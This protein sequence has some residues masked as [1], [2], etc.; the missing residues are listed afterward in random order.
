MTD[1]ED[2]DH[3][4]LA[5]EMTDEIVVEFS[6]LLGR[7][8]TEEVPDSGLQNA[9]EEAERLI[10]EIDTLLE[11]DVEESEITQF[12]LEEYNRFSARVLG[13]DNIETDSL[14][15]LQAVFEAINTVLES[16]RFQIEK[17]GHPEYYETVEELV[18]LI[19]EQDD[20]NQLLAD[21]IGSLERIGEGKLQRIFT[22]LDKDLQFILENPE[23][24]TEAT[25]TEYLR[26][27]ERCCEQFKTLSPFVI[28]S[29][30]VI[31]EKTGNID[32][33]LTDNLSTLV[34]MCS[35]RQRIR[36][37]ARPIDNDT[38]NAVAHDDFLIDPVN[39][40]V[41]FSTDGDTEVWSYTEIRKYVV[42]A[43]CAALSLFVF[44]FL[45]QHRENVQ[46]LEELLQE[47]EGH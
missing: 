46:E 18:D 41:E 34:E 6:R 22:R 13:I 25:A 2:I 31:G 26:M 39:E 8:L 7:D 3:E 16:I 24:E 12:M 33:R 19:I 38:R 35:K 44:P 14:E 9:Y 4:E 47:Q 40:T 28:F 23:V 43:R 20:S 17:L 37:L 11:P 21:I 15:G 36:L 1:S 45:L 5:K 29:T 10:E 27:Y 30:N 42:E 32:E